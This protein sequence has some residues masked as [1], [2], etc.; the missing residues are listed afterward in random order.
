MPFLILAHAGDY[1]AAR[2]AAELQRRHGYERVR[3]V[4]AE[5]LVL[6]PRLSHRVQ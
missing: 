5:E 4:T 1:V 3:L 6:A 2:V